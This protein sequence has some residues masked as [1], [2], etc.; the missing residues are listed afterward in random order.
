MISGFVM[1]FQMY[2]LF[3]LHSFGYWY[4]ACAT[5]KW[6]QIRSG[7]IKNLLNSFKALK[8]IYGSKWVAGVSLLV[9]IA[10]G[11]PEIC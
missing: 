3:L 7:L 8:H 1:Q 11:K 10:G 2:T 5:N 4:T 6:E 9:M